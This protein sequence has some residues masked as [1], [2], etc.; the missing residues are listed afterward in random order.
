MDK[1]NDQARMTALLR[2]SV[3]ALV[4]GLRRHIAVTRSAHTQAHV[5]LMIVSDL[6]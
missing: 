4:N 6:R 1:T 2:N 5:R 3:R